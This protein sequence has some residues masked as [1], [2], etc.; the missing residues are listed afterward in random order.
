M[1]I[2]QGVNGVNR[3]IKQIYQ[4]VN[5]INNV[6]KERWEMVNNIWRKVYSNS[7][8]YEVYNVISNTIYKMEFSSRSYAITTDA[9]NATQYMNYS[10]DVNTGVITL[11]EPRKRVS[12]GMMEIGEYF[13]YRGSSDASSI[14]NKCVIESYRDNDVPR[15]YNHSSIAV[16]TKHKGNKINEVQAKDGAYPSNGIQGDYWYI[17]K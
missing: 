9:S 12:P 14:L 13:Y 5:G 2:Y 10:L 11:L 16:T 7:V 3:E 4:S 8:T 6:I 17:K 15:I 1:S